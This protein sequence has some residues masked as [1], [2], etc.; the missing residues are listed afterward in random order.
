MI[1]GSRDFLLLLLV[2]FLPGIASGSLIHLF[3][4]N[5]MHFPSTAAEHPT[6]RFKVSPP[7]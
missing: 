7:G 5:P 3:K 1:V 2:F 4:P 6:L